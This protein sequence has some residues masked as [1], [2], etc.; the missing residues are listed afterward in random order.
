[1]ICTDARNMAFTKSKEAVDA[2]ISWLQN[3]HEKGILHGDPISWSVHVK[4]K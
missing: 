4:K 3:N 2:F 1:V